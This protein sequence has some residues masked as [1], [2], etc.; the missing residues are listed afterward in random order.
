MHFCGVRMHFC[1]VRVSR[2]DKIGWDFVGFEFLVRG[3][4]PYFFDFELL[5][6]LVFGLGFLVEVSG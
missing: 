5:E 1:E 4:G 6:F 2:V 3:V